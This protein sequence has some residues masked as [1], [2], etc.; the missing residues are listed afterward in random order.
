MKVWLCAVAY[1]LAVIT[2]TQRP[3]PIY[4]PS[5]EMCDEFEVDPYATKRCT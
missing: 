4:Y 5:A 2:H 3:E 1:L